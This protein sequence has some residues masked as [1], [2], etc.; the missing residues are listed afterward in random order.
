MESERH[1]FQKRLYGLIGQNL[2]SLFDMWQKMGWPPADIKERMDVVEKQILDP[3]NEMVEEETRHSDEILEKIQQRGREYFSLSKELHK[4]VDMKSRDEKFSTMTYMEYQNSLNEEVKLL[5]WEKEERMKEVYEAVAKNEAVCSKMK[6]ETK[7]ISQKVIPTKEQLDSV[8]QH[9]KDMEAEYLRRFGK[10]AELKLEIINL[11]EQMKIEPETTFER[12]VCC[13]SDEAMILS[14]SNIEGVEKMFQDLRSRMEASIKY[15]ASLQDKI[16]S[17]HQKLELGSAEDFLNENRGFSKPVLEELEAKLKDLE[18]LKLQH[19][20]DFIHKIR[21]EL[22]GWWQLC[23]YGSE[24]RQQFKPFSSNNFTEKLLEE[25]EQELERIKTY[26]TENKPLFDMVKE[27]QDL[28]AKRLELERLTKDPTRLGNYKI[29]AQE[30]KDRK[31]VNTRLPKIETKLFEAIEHYEAE[32]GRA[33]LVGGVPFKNY[34]EGQVLKHESDLQAEKEQRSNIKKQMNYHETMYGSLPANANKT[35]IKVSNKRTREENTPHGKT[36]LAKLEPS[37]SAATSTMSSARSAT[38]T[39]GG[40]SR[41]AQKRPDPSQRRALGSRND[42]IITGTNRV[43]AANLDSIDSNACQA[44]FHMEAISSTFRFEP[45]VAKRNP[46]ATAL[47][48]PKRTFVKSSTPMTFPASKD[49][50]FRTPNSR[51][52]TPIN[53]NKT[54]TLRS[55]KRLPFLI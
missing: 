35:T 12:K 46:G 52:L 51:A 20:E 38:L 28:W 55:G 6:A 22:M 34:W 24:E 50:V 19:L 47:S 11:Y 18:V 26:Y 25:H 31:R 36:K 48:T 7:Y 37:Q 4:P 33:F 15:S 17:L 3:L 2:N 8:K 5:R 43:T 9:T 29:L 41:Y 13:E 23:Y 42:T 14:N 45:E 1:A 30:E 10:F 44:G 53:K 39:R 21:D 40:V 32:N 49:F 54:L 27:C 16:R